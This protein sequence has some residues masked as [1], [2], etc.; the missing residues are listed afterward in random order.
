MPKSPGAAGTGL[1]VREKAI[2]VEPWMAKSR[3]DR[4][5]QSGLTAALPVKA[6][7]PKSPGAAGTGL[8][9]REKAIVVEPWMAKSRCDRSRQSGLIASL[10]VEAWMPKSPGAAET[11]LRVR[12]KA[13][14][15]QLSTVSSL[16][17]R[18]HRSSHRRAELSLMPSITVSRQG[19]TR[20]K[21]WQPSSSHRRASGGPTHNI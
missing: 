1:C 13:I 2:V 4:S 5:R 8:R 9:V 20:R 6:W 11:G 19:A 3:C 14:G 21:L 15:T 10:P 7:M 17:Q 16:A 12:E 18:G